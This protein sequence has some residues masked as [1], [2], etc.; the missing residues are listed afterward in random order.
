MGFFK[1]VF[2]PIRKIAKKIIPKEVKPFLPYIASFYGGPLLGKGLASQFGTQGIMGKA[3][4]RN[5]IAKGLVSGATAAA[6][7]EDANILRSSLLAAAPDLLQGGLG[8]AGK[9]LSGN[10]VDEFKPTLKQGI[11]NLLTKASDSDIITRAANPTS[12]TGINEIIDVAKVAG[13]QTSV[14]QAAK[15]AELNEQ[16]IADYNASLLS[17]GMEDKGARRDAIYK[18]FLRNGYEEERI[19][20]MLDTY[21]YAQGGIA[22]LR[23]GYDEGGTVTITQKEYDRLTKDM[24]SKEGLGFASEGLNMLNKSGHSTEPVPMLR[25]AQGGEVIEDT[26][27]D[28]VGDVTHRIGDEMEQETIRILKND[29]RRGEDISDSQIQSMAEAEA[30]EKIKKK[31]PGIMSIIEAQQFAKGGEVEEVVEESETLMAGGPYKSG[32]DVQDAFSVWSGM[33]SDDKSLFEGFLDFYKQGSW[34]DQIQGSVEVEE[35]TMM[36]S[37]PGRQGDYDNISML[38]F[39][40]PYKELF[41]EEVEQMQEYLQSNM[42]AG[43]ANGGMIGMAL[44]GQMNSAPRNQMKEIEGQMAGPDWFTKRVEDLMNF[45]G[46][47]YEEASERAYNEGPLG[48]DYAK[49]GRVNYV[50]GGIMNRNLLNTGMDKDM[51]GGGFIPEGTKEKADDVPARL[52]KNEFVMTADAVKAAGGGS[53]NKGAQRMYNIMNQLEA[54]A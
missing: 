45:E 37:G 42:P 2:R 49:G 53:V 10:V 13:V 23:S 46:L 38:L 30:I 11:G 41:P 28:S 21:G 40:K 48:D 33:G 31:Y 4:L 6:T 25:F 3:F 17:G 52:S 29:Y 36:A 39:G 18:I 27:M 35:D 20:T 34:R 1:K 9:A 8:E 26:F 24:D 47:S 22:G 51:R 7:D 50:G 5:A 32:R 44:G 54:K 16:S 12:R 43:A 14:D 19:N 15:F